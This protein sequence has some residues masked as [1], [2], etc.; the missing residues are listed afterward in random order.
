VP[1]ESPIE[2]DPVIRRI[3]AVRPPVREDDLS[4]DS[5]SARAIAERV[6][7]GSTST[8]SPKSRE[9][10]TRP[11]W[12][13]PRVGLALAPVAAV[14]VLLLA[15][16]FSGPDSSGTQPAGAA[17]IRAAIHALATS[18]AIFV[19]DQTYV[20]GPSVHGHPYTIDQVL[21]TPTGSGSQS[22]LTTYSDPKALHQNAAQTGWA[23]GDGTQEIY[24]RA[25]NTIYASSIWGSYLHPGRRPGTYVYRYARGAPLSINRPVAL[26]AAQARA[27][28]NGTVAIIPIEGTDR[29]KVRYP[30]NAP[31][32]AQTVQDEI[33]SHMLHYVGR[34]TVDG[35]TALELVGSTNGEQS[36]DA[37]I[38][39]DPTTHL[40]FEEVDQ[41]GTPHQQ[42]IHVSLRKLPI[43]PA[44]ERLVSLHALHPTAR[45]DRS[46]EDY[47][48]AAGG[49]QIY[50]G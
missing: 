19:E 32:Y 50:G 38:Y 40:P 34:G 27:L 48:R 39:L 47:L 5:P 17:V 1:I 21:E 28:R 4:P 26:T 20:S 11:Q 16:A 14:V 45:I 6:L 25:T 3:A 43:T 15:G 42:V 31:G 23:Y 7:A 18:G 33:R 22:V 24:S 49:T 2:D 29:V 46:H 10:W 9:R 41:P 37:H 13:L 30:G 44:T 12:V 36:G 8:T 35:R